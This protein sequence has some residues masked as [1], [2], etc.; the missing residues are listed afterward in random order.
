MPPMSPP[1]D[2]PQRPAACPSCGSAEVTTAGKHTDASSYWRCEKCGEVWNV[3]RRQEPARF[4]YS[5]R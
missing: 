2:A 4:T 1:P 5:R 3:G